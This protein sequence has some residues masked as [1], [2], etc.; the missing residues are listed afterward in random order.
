MASI[1]LIFIIE[2]T[3]VFMMTRSL[4][5]L[6]LSFEDIAQIRVESIVHVVNIKMTIPTSIEGAPS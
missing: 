1:T 4:S 6:K 5:M 3:L 2:V